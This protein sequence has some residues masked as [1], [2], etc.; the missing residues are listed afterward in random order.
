[1]SRVSTLWAFA[2]LSSFV[3]GCGAPPLRAAVLVAARA[4]RRARR[5]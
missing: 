2:T 4:Y 3:A 1:L 5:L